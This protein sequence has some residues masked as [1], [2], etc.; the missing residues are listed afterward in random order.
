MAND[1]VAT[2]KHEISPA[3]EPA[4]AAKALPE[5]GPAAPA[6]PVKAVSPPAA[7]PPIVARPPADPTPEVEKMKA[8]APVQPAGIKQPGTAKIARVITA[9]KVKAVKTVRSRLPRPPKAHMAPQAP[10]APRQTAAVL[11]AKPVIEAVATPLVEIP[12]VF[13]SE[14]KKLQ[15]VWFLKGLDTGDI[16][17]ANAELREVVETSRHAA[18]DGIGAMSREM[19]KFFQH[20]LDESFS[21]ARDLMNAKNLPELVELQSKLLQDSCEACLDHSQKL[22]DIARQTAFSALRP[23]SD[24]WAQLTG[25]FGKTGFF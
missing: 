5:A 9:P 6:E 23:L 10:R 1:P 20:S 2:P 7:P 24:N 8:A 11:A 16:H 18:L 22:N 15:K 17:I 21:A 3:A 14:M 19:G 25:G 12:R 13:E 4:P